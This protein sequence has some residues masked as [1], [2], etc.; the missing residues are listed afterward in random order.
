MTFAERYNAKVK[1][2]MPS[3]ADDLM[4]DPNT[5]KTASHI[6][7]HIFHRSE[8]LGG[9]CSVILALVGADK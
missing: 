2:I 6:D 3:M 5:V 9:M 8:Y 4:V 1:E 7:E